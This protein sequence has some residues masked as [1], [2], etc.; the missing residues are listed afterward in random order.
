MST[1][2]N[3]HGPAGKGK[4]RAKRERRPKRSALFL[5]GTDGSLYAACSTPMPPTGF[6]RDAEVLLAVRLSQKEQQIALDVMHTEGIIA[7]AKTLVGILRP[8]A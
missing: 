8:H 4:P 6:V 7:A 3:G 2:G 1:G 5:L